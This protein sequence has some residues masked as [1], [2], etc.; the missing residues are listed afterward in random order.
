MPGPPFDFPAVTHANDGKDFYL[1]NTTTPHTHLT[2][3]QAETLWHRLSIALF[4]PE[5]DP[6][7]TRAPNRK[8]GG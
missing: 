2:R 3:E 1:M 4:Y 5:L 7:A 6:N 8:R